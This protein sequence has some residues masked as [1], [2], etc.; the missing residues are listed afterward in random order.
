MALLAQPE[1]KVTTSRLRAVELE[2]RLPL[3]HNQ[4]MELSQIMQHTFSKRDVSITALSNI[5]DRSVLMRMF[6]TR[7]TKTGKATKTTQL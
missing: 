5:I 2:F 7:G 3:F 1:E 4:T 6:L